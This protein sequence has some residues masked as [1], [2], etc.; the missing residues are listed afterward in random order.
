MFAKNLITVCGTLSEDVTLQTTNKSHRL[1]TTV[2][3][4]VPQEEIDKNGK[5]VHFT[6]KCIAWDKQA[7][8]L[9]T[10][11]KGQSIRIFGELAKT[12]NKY[13]HERINI[14]IEFLESLNNH[15]KIT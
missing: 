10:F 5:H 15:L 4:T 13:G 3:I 9:A 8:L 1:V 7:S 2:R 6:V 11:K 12:N 14:K